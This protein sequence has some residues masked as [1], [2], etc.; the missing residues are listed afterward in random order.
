M[1]N[2]LIWA[3]L[4][5]VAALAP[6]AKDRQTKRRLEAAEPRRAGA[7]APVSGLA[8]A[9]MLARATSLWTDG[10]AVRC[11]VPALW[12]TESAPRAAFA[13]VLRMRLRAARQVAG[14]AWTAQ[15]PLVLA[16]AND[17]EIASRLIQ[18]PGAVRVLKGASF[19]PRRALLGA[20]EARLAA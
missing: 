16:A 12:G 15:E 6:P 10:A 9:N 19:K 20:E 4:A 5:V 8:A 1:R 13:P 2:A 18:G 7:A 3:L 11:R 14:A 17:A